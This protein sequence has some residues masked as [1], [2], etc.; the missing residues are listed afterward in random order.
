MS[1]ALASKEALDTWPEGFVR[2][3]GDREAL[4]VLLGLASLLPRRLLRLAARHRRAA[5]CLAAARRG[6]E[7]SASDRARAAAT[8]GRDVLAA[9]DAAGARLVVPADEEFPAEVLELSDPPAGL[10]VRGAPLTSMRPRVAIV[11]ARRASVGGRDTARALARALADTG[12]CTVS[13]GARGIDAEAH[14]G[15]LAAGGS[16]VSVLGSGIDLLYPRH[17]AALF[18]EIE[19]AG[20]IVS[21]YPPGVP[22]DAWRFPA[23]NRIIAALSVAVVIVE[24]TRR[25]GSKI[26]A[27]HALDVGRDVF[28]VP[29]PITSELAEAP[30][31]LIREGAGLI[32]GPDDLLAD[33][34][35][36]P[37]V[38]RSAGG[39][40]TANEADGTPHAAWPSLSAE[41]E[42]V[43]T[44]LV[45][46]APADMV[47]D[48]TGLAIP[49]T[50]A[51]LSSLE[52]RGLVRR[53]GGRY[54]RTPS[55]AR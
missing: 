45:A 17:N 4:A 27:D 39:D 18:A 6:D 55:F 37:R 49:V 54:E 9:A 52:L 20:A 19:A 21:E 15:A 24:G 44:A 33:L 22:A 47:A 29:G 36:L 41:Q 26:T 1:T 11:G 51:A 50:I 23:R 35:L 34:G 31:Q 53:S 13:G 32:R 38:S 7:V 14:R 48:V 5:A 12:A 46:A 2:S 10:F 40:S 25:S 28:A 3:R 16:T 43:L 42:R 30:L 8:D